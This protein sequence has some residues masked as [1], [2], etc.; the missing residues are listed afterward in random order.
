MLCLIILRITG[1]LGLNH[2]Y[3]L[4]FQVNDIVHYALCYGNVFLKEVKIKL[5]L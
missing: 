3:L 5:G 2:V 4:N 1:Y